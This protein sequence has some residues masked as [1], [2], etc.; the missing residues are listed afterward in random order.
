MKLAFI[1]SGGTIASSNGVVSQAKTWRSGLER[2]GHTVDLINMWESHDWAE[3]DAII[4]F[5]FNNY[6]SSHIIG[7][8]NIN[9]NIFVAPILDP[10]YSVFRLKIYAHWGSKKFNLTNAYHSL[11]SVKGLVKGFLVRSEFEQSYIMSGFGVGSGKCHIVPLSFNSFETPS[12]IEKERFCLHI[13]LLTDE[14]K[15]VKR[16]IEAAKKYNFKLVLGGLL[17]NDKERAI[18]YSW[19]GDA[20]NIEFKGFLSEEEKAMLYNRAKVFALPSTN[21]GVGIVG[22]EA[23]SAGCDIVVTSL[24]GPKEYYSNL[25]KVV[26]PYSIDEIGKAISTLL[27]DTTY[28][29]ELREHIVS[30]YNLDS[31]S[32]KLEQ[33]FIQ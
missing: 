5:G 22:L 18:L 12:S 23:A 10:V 4:Y 32:Q 19:I 11:S 7:L 24:G 30:S 15:N 28:Q 27:G 26:N 31:V 14:R 21:E 9:K 17:R 29:P 6:M 2:R 20:K 16:L 13:S 3:F 1:L 8:K 33:L 25:A